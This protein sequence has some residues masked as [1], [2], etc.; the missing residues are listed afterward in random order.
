MLLAIIVVVVVVVVVVII[1]VI[2]TTTIIIITITI[3][4][5]SPFSPRFK[6]QL[7]PR[8]YFN[9]LLAALG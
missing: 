8:A 1:F 3:R 4:V 6:E 2:T 7:S 9:W 5:L